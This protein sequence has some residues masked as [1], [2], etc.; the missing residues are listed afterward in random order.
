MA[1]DKHFKPIIKPLQQI[2]DSSVRAIKRQSRDDNAAS[3]PPSVREKRRR[4]RRKRK[5]ARRSSVPRPRVN[6]MIDRTIV[7][8][9]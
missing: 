7:Y 9:R 2:V 3:V 5:Q 8:S 1:L 6:L 4:R